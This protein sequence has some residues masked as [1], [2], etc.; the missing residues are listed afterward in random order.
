MMGDVDTIVGA[1][2]ANL[3]AWH[4]VSLAALAIGSDR[5]AGWWLAPQLAPSIYHSAISLERAGGR[6][7]GRRM[8]ADLR[9]WADRTGSFL[10]VCDSFGVLDLRALGVEHRAR[11]PWYERPPLRTHPL[12]H[13]PVPDGLVVT[14]VTTVEDLVAFERTMVRSYG[15]RPP[16][17]DLDIHAPGILASGD[18][19]VLLGRLDGTPVGVAMAHRAAGIVGVYGVGVVPDARGRG[20]AT[21]VTHRAVAVAA[22]L[23]VVLQPS[24]AAEA[25]YRRLGFTG[26]GWYDHWA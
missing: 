4:A 2:A 13:D 24:P 1:G 20:V 9:A 19:H 22:D 18:L 17:T 5:Q 15:A 11:V 12:P 26:S 10:S 23:P 16:V 14:R 6:T 8:V 25:L 3:A 21:A 7:E